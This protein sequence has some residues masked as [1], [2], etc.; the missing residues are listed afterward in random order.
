MIELL[1][2]SIAGFV[3]ALVGSMS[4]GGAGIIQLA[5]LL[6]IGLP[7]NSAVATHIF[8]DAGFYPSALRNFQ[9]ARQ[10]KWR[11]MPPIIALNL[12]ATA[13]GTL[14]IVYL[15]EDWLGRLI[16]VSL[17]VILFFIVRDKQSPEKERPAARIWPLAYVTARFSAAGGFGNNLLAVL[18]LI[19]LRG[20]TALQAVA[21][22]FLA[23]GLSSLLAVGILL[24]SGL[25]DFRLGIVL[26]A[27]NFIGA[28]LG[29]RISIKRGNRF[30]RYMIIS[31][32]VG[33]IAYL[34]FT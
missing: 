19:C 2:V 28:W 6:Y 16:A 29:S 11:I 27:A 3:A 15:D 33:V 31:M 22:A 34:L 18:A 9:R 23:N 26:F 5:A 32:A 13:G 21:A 17:I 24:F 25:I 1:V 12:L 4:G 7:V 8:G 10:I 14:L 30:V 20:L